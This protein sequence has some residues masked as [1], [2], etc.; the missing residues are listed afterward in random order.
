M[1]APPSCPSV[2][3]GRARPLRAGAPAA[4]RRARRRGPRPGSRRRRPARAVVPGP[5]G[6]KKV[7]VGVANQKVVVRQVDLPWLPADELRRSLPFQVQDFLPMPVDQAILD[8]HPLE[9]FTSDAVDGC[10]ASCSSPPPATW[11][12]TPSR[13]S[14]RRPVADHG[15]PHPL[16]RPAR[17]RHAAPAFA[18]V[19]AEALVDVGASVTNI[20]VHQAGVPRF[21]RVLLRAAPTS[22]S[23]SPSGSAYPSTTPRRSSRHRPRA[24]AGAAG[25]TPRGRHR[26][27]RRRLRRGGARL[28]RL[29][30]RPD[31]TARIDRVVLSGGGARWSGSVERLAAATRLPV[32]VAR[33]LSHLGSAAP[34][35]P[36]STRLHRAP[37]R[38]PR[39]SRPGVAS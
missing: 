3:P 23:R 12:A 31:G 10:C 25:Q 18:E 34:A 30:P 19:D 9:E 4:R 15:R 13:L 20:V 36:T 29:L 21:V 38:R 26:V 2:G 35:C 1:C 39:R 6:T 22:P 28:A 32:E 7:I 17:R 8:F 37:R 33:P 24:R 27:H 11:S 14:R 16:R 5:F